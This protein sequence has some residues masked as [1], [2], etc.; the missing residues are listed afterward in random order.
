MVAGDIGRQPGNGST[1]FPEEQSIQSPADA[2]L[3]GKSCEEHAM[4]TAANRK[5]GTIPG[6]TRKKRGELCKGGQDCSR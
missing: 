3:S 4:T 1:I 6:C 5:S 2:Y